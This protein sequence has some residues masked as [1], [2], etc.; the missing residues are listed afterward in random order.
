MFIRFSGNFFLLLWVRP[1]PMDLFRTSLWPV[2]CRFATDPL[3]FKV[4]CR[5]LRTVK[6][7][8]FPV[9][10]TPRSVSSNSGSLIFTNLGH[11][12]WK[13]LHSPHIVR[14]TRTMV[15][16]KLIR[17]SCHR[18]TIVHTLLSDG[19]F[20]KLIRLRRTKVRCNYSLEDY[21]D[22]GVQSQG[23]LFKTYLLYL[24]YI[25]VE[26]LLIETVTFT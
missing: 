1:E 5:K 9:R 19:F 20:F 11:L 2:S 7:R 14:Y 10:V 16:S 26:V 25:R 23:R 8:I 17:S 24:R 13:G 6:K 21:W 3:V 18:Q 4:G 22:R 15:I 12:F